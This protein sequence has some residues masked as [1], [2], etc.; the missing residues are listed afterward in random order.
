MPIHIDIHYKHNTRELSPPVS[1]KTLNQYSSK[2]SNTH[3]KSA[4]ITQS[5]IGLQTLD[6]IM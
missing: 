5:R 3:P 4:L 2:F 1:N 6:F